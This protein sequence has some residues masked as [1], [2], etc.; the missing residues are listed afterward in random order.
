MKNLIFLVM[1]LCFG[2]GACSQKDSQAPNDNK[3]GSR[4]AGSGQQADKHASDTEDV[5][6]GDATVAEDLVHIVCRCGSKPLGGKG[7]TQSQIKAQ[8]QRACEDH[9]SDTLSK[10]QEVM[11]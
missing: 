1:V 6:G 11:P 3:Q 5:E 9:F 8:L 4:G 10:C 7:E 2:L